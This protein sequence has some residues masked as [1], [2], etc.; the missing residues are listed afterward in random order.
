[1][2][3][4]KT[5]GATIAAAAAAFIM[6]GTVVAAGE[7]AHAAAGKNVHC[8]GVN[9]CKGKTACK[10][11]GNACKGQNACKGKGFVAISKEACDAIG[12]TVK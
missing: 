4:T 2:K 3:L 6:S 1:M 7:M 11:A 9:V 8:Y 12:G 5:S 10:T